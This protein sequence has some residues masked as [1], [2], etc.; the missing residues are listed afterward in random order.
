[1]KVLIIYYSV[2]H[3]N[4]EKVAK[5]ISEV[6]DAKLERVSDVDANS[7]SEYDLV[8]FGSG[9]YF[10]KHHAALLHIVDKLP[11][12]KKKVFIFSTRGI[13]ITGVYHRALKEKLLKKKCDIIGDFSCKGFNTYGPFKL[14]GGIN[15]GR[16][17]EKDLENARD[18]AAF[19]K[20][21]I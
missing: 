2:H 21:R 13:G 17:N 15:K 20:D 12:L 1:M 18:F 6:L 11:I 14:I 4:T 7:V 19:L 9:I 10:S 3:N 16:P 8:G 5:A